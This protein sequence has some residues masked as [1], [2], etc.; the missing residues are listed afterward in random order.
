MLKLVQN[1]NWEMD[2]SERFF[3]KEAE[4][5]KFFSRFQTMGNSFMEDSYTNIKNMGQELH[6]F[7]SLFAYFRAT[8]KLI[9][10]K[11]QTLLERCQSL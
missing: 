9:Y 11:Y 4:E 10:Q 1:S 7:N 6:T 5:H 2:F 3:E 8:I